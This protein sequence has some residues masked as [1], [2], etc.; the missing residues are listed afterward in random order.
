[1]KI[2]VNNANKY[3]VQNI[4]F[5]KLIIVIIVTIMRLILKVLKLRFNQFKKQKIKNKDF[6]AVF[7]V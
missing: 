6:S 2:N 3:F 1:M 5:L 7:F 4:V